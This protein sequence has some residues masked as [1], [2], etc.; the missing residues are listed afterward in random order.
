MHHEQG[1]LQRR[2]GTLSAIS[3]T[4]GAVI[5]SGIFLKPLAISQAMPS[6]GWIYLFW[7][8]LGL[9]CLCGAF[10]YAELGA[11]FPQAG[12]QY[13]FLREAWGP[14]AAFLY[15]WVF[16]WAINSG[17]VA[18][19]GA[20]FSEY[21]LPWFGFSVDQAK[22]LPGQLCAAG[23]IVV[24]AAINHFGVMV[25]AA[26]QNVSTLAKVGALVLIALAGFFAGGEPHGTA[27]VASAATGETSLS[28]KGIVAVFLAIFWAYEGWYQ[29]PFNAAELKDPNRALPRGL[30]L[31][32]FILIGIYLAVNLTYLRVVPFEEMRAMG[33]DTRAVA[34]TTIGRT[35]GEGWGHGLTLLVALSVFGAANPNFLSSPRGFYAMAQDGLMPR[36]L[37]DVHPR[38]NTP[39][40]AIWAQAVW[41]IA[42]VFLVPTFGNLSDFVVFA[43][44]LF[45]GLTVAGVYRMRIKRPDLPRPYRCTGYPITPAFF[46][47]VSVLF[48]G[49][50]LSDS[51]EQK[52]ALKGLLVLATGIVAWF[53]VANRTC[54]IAKS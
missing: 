19:L 30:I 2:L 40:I 29:L 15:G 9:V 36:V 10:A 8:G 12:G 18:A 51:D 45:Y 24:L 53:A 5:G 46:V 33:T 50:L 54:R 34:S 28:I 11:M 35:F 48:V 31:G 13:A 17:T 16:F 23:M 26:V 22:G 49:A 20:A 38:F 42:L 21:V 47:I 43:S 25:G 1:H 27:Q 44:F 3:I 32:M 7:A 52:N 14:F 41:A 6:E 4:V 37:V 39:V